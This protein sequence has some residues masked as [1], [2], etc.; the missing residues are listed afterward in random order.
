[1]SELIVLCLF[2][3]F[4][5]WGNNFVILKMVIKALAIRKGGSARSQ[6]LCSL[7]TVRVSLGFS[8]TT[9]SNQENRQKRVGWFL[10]CTCACSM[11]LT[12]H[13]VGYLYSNP[14]RLLRGCLL[15]VPPLPLVW[16]R[17]RTCWVQPFSTCASNP[18]SIRATVRVRM[19][20]C[21]PRGLCQH[22]APGLQRR[23]Q[24]QAAFAQPASQPEARSAWPKRSGSISSVPTL[25][26]P[27]LL[28]PLPG[29]GCPRAPAQGTVL[30]PPTRSV[31]PQPC[32]LS[33]PGGLRGA[34]RLHVEHF[35]CSN[36][37]A[38][39]AS[40]EENEPQIS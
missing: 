18:G 5:I 17:S 3:V 12:Q 6:V 9:K 38:C 30:L 16:L 15:C 2:G 19:S 28:S 27:R 35:S 32:S 4:C 13:H 11:L 23:R 14:R 20:Y 29:Q 31:W 33:C 7:F 34:L 36:I 40:K 1:M 25:H 37:N 10:T 8:S 24:Q 26:V 39:A 22:A 21:T